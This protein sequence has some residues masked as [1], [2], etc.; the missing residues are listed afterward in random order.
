VSA[1]DY[2][3][4]VLWV[5]VLA[6]GLVTQAFRVS[7]ILLFGRVDEVPDRLARVLRYVPAAVL[8][9]LVAP[10]VLAP[11]GD[12][13]VS[14]VANGAVTLAADLGGSVGPRTGA[15]TV[16]LVVAWRTGNVAAT[17]A[18]GMVTLWSIGW[19][20]GVGFF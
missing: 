1:T 6:A 4:G 10:A 14:L 5:A 8:A 18:V 17:I 15:A 19:L 7:F 13:P 12:P 16:A 3:P 20:A 11:S 2:A 9:A